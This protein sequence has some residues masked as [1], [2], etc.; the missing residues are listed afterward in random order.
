MSDNSSD[1]P[2]SGHQLE[3]EQ[4]NYERIPHWVLFHPEVSANA[5]RLYLVLQSYA[6]GRTSSFPSRRA[7]AD[8]PN[9]RTA[10]SAVSGNSEAAAHRCGAST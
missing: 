10:S 3:V 7:I 2:E 4:P 9:H 5:V 6:M 1:L 8:A